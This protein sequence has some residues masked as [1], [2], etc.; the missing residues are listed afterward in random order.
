MFVNEM[1]LI[2]MNPTKDNQSYMVVEALQEGVRSWKE[3]LRVT[4]G[5]L[6]KDKWLY[7]VRVCYN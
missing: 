4:G 5:E 7:A 3:A 2:E 6:N 1:D